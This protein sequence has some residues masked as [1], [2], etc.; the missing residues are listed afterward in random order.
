VRSAVIALCAAVAA[1]VVAAGSPAS[2][3]ARRAY[4][5][6][7]SPEARQRVAPFAARP[8]AGG[9]VCAEVPPAM[10]ETLSATPGLTFLGYEEL[11]R[12]APIVTEESFST[13]ARSAAAA[14]PGRTCP[15]PTFT[16][17]VGWG[18]K[19]MYGDPNL[20][21]PSGG[22]GIKVGV[23]DTGVAPHLDIVRRLVKCMDLTPA[24]I[25]PPC[26]DSMNHGTLVA[27]VIAA[28]GGEDGAGMWGMAPEVAIYSYRVCN[29][30]LECW[31]SYV[32][33]GIYAAIADGVNIINMSLDGPGHDAAIRAAIDDAV[34][35]NILVVVAAGNSPP[36]SYVGYP[37][38]YPE[39]VTVGAIKENLDPWPFTASGVNDGD[40]VHEIN[41][42]EV[43]GP[44]A[45]V[46][47]A[48]KSGCWVLG[49]GTSLAA[50][51]VSG[52]AVKLWDG[53]AATTRARIQRA[54][55][56]RDLYVAGDDT[57]TGFGL[58]TLRDY[59][60]RYVINASG[61]P[62]GA[63]A[64]SGAI[65]LAPGSAQSFSIFPSN[66][67]HLL[68]DV[69]V[70]GVSQGP[71]SSYTF[72]DVRSDHTI[73]VTATK[74][75]PYAIVASAGPAGSISPGGT[76]LVACGTNQTYTITPPSGCGAIQDVKVDGVSQG[77]IASYTFTNVRTSHTIEA[78]ISSTSN[79]TITTSVINPGGTVS[80]SGAV[81]VACGSNQTFT[82][83]P[84]TS[85]NR[86]EVIIIDGA[87]TEPR[88]NYTFVNVRSDH[89]LEVA[90]NYA[91]TSLIS[92]SASPGGT[93]SPSGNLSVPCGVDQTYTMT[94]TP[95]CGQIER[96]KID[97][98]WQGPLA[99]YTFK[100]V[101]SDHTI[102]AVFS[103]TP[104]SITAT[105]GEGAT[106]SPSGASSVGCGGRLTYAI[107]PSDACHVITDVQVDGVSVGVV[108]SYTF[109][110]VHSSHTIA[111]TSAPSGLALA[112]THT[113]ASWSGGADG[114]I[115]LAVTGGVPP[116]QY[117]WS[118]GETREDLAALRAGTYLVRVTDSQGCAGELSVMI[119]SVGPAELALSPPAPNPT[120]GAMRVRYGMPAPGTARL[121]VHDVQGREVALLANGP[122]SPGW[123]NAS[124]NGEIGGVR[125]PGG[126][127][128]LMLRAGGRQIVQRF[129]LVR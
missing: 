61:G 110:D 33:D 70:D 9:I 63:V 39:V 93:I 55:R 30:S 104:L 27:S 97:A 80:P 123:S 89:T 116:Y 98:V 53:D 82:F 119:V 38:A 86:T 84:A 114:A 66:D 87:A 44:G 12:P 71:I 60:D 64:P 54:A 62:G 124:W 26:A 47:A 78:T 20:V 106:I 23:I 59:S 83:T 37:G 15:F 73:R 81:S 17:P 48:M 105:A 100:K 4:F 58:P 109:S 112:E 50:P 43:A 52:L 21:R 41:E 51:L 85:C 5:R 127:Y 7:A 8:L 113:G 121:S 2:A 111:V 107:A 91:Y 96:V 129:A 67:C 29:V 125:A 95:G 120:A 25:L 69:V 79:Y 3:A 6:V 22:A 28:D 117:A 31:G 72:P 128:F 32:A 94:P 126:V 14:D 34:A 11:Y 103:S 115:D 13:A 74:L 10:I 24:H 108:N 18:I 88:T 99:S 102:Q 68:Q 90:F 65:A 36:Y 16:P 57:L 46:L 45:G 35:H 40:Y 101:R 118:N 49:A 92:A 76:T 75:G 19:A 42:I 56:F 122:Q 1:L 77:P